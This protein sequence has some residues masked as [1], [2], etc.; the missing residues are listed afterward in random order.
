MGA[1]RYGLIAG[2]YVSSGYQHGAQANA[3][4]GGHMLQIF[5]ARSVVEDFVYHSLPYGLPVE[6]TR[7]VSS[8]LAGKEGLID[9]Q[10]RILLNPEIF[11]SLG[12]GRIF[13][14]CGAWEFLGGDP[15]ME[16]SRAA[17]VLE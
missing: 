11:T 6:T 14:Y 8:W 17:F 10:V 2:G 15:T 12:Q 4:L 9:G 16:G 1:T 3:I 13:H 5:I 7:S